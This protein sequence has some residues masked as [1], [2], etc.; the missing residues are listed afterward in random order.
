METDPADPEELDESAEYWLYRGRRDEYLASC[1]RLTEHFGSTS[2]ARVAERV[3][4]ACLLSPAPEDVLA[5]A[6]TLIDRAQADQE[7]HPSWLGAY[8]L[9][10]KGLAEYRHGRPAG[11][12][13]IMDG[14]ASSTLQ[15]APR[16]VSAMARHRLGREEEALRTLA[17]AI[18]AGDWE[19]SRATDRERWIYHI[20][21]REAEG[22]ILPLA[23]EGGEALVEVDQRP[24]RGAPVV[25]CHG[26]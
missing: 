16:L 17:A 8:F 10:A 6:T 23:E 22:M 13:A 25:V 1:R 9:V 26:G 20:L 12:T 4:R 24:G 21:R 14:P 15:P 5:K 11:A 3:G 2:D 18:L 19:R 7:K